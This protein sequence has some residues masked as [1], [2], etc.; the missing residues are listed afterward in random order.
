MIAFG[1][2]NAKTFLCPG[3]LAE[4]LGTGKRPPPFSLPQAP[5]PGGPNQWP[6]TQKKEQVNP[7]HPAG[8]SRAGSRLYRAKARI[9]S[10]AGR[11][12]N[13]ALELVL[14]VMDV[15]LGVPVHGILHQFQQQWDIG[16]NTV[17]DNFMQGAFHPGQCP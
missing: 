17:N 1:F 13:S 3:Q 10:E 9:N 16:G 11:L 2:A 8:M 14:E 6:C 12:G 15:V 5:A 4:T 7:K